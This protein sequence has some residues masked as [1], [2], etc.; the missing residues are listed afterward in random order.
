MD[1]DP[2]ELT[3][4]VYITPLLCTCVLRLRRLVCVLYNKACQLVEE[5]IEKIAKIASTSGHEYD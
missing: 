2:E 4:D 1:D 3:I 5:I